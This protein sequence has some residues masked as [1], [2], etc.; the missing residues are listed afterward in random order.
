MDFTYD[1]YR[2]ILS[3]VVDKGY[4]F[5]QYDNYEDNEK[6]VILRHD[7]D[8]S[9]TDAKKF[10]EI[11]SE[12][13]S[14]CCS[15]YFFLITSDFY[16]L[17]SKESIDS[18]DRILSLGHSVGLHF[19]ETKYFTDGGWSNEE[20]IEK[21]LYEKDIMERMLGVG[22][23]SISMHRPSPKTLE[24]DLVVPGMVNTYSQPFFTKIK[25]VSDSYHRWREDVFSIIESAAYDRLHILTHPFWYHEDSLSRKEAFEKYLKDGYDYRYTLI[26]NNVLPPNTTLEQSFKE[27]EKQ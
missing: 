27:E 16:N 7:V 23:D 9:I 21:I 2:T 25:Y 13:D 10:A 8:M 11:E 18:I 24:S 19:D 14:S 5:S 1:E 15:V 22:I 26:E 4:V 12:F 20:I 3:K 17:F 6:S